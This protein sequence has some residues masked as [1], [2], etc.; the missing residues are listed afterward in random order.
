MPRLYSLTVHINLTPYH[1]RSPVL[2]MCITI[3]INFICC[4]SVTDTSDSDTNS[5]TVLKT[6]GNDLS[7]DKSAVMRLN[8]SSV[9]I[10]N[11]QL[12]Y[13]DPFQTQNF[14]EFLR[15]GAG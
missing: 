7:F 8:M 13:K 6:K 3:I 2:C 14:S 9:Q 5:V 11:F 15:H 12:S 1:V 4:H 10:I